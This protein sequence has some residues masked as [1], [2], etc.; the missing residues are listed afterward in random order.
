MDSFVQAIGEK[1]EFRSQDDIVEEILQLFGR[2]IEMLI[3]FKA[4]RG[5]QVERIIQGIRE[6]M[7]TNAI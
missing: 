3:L 2:G 4:S 1:A 5:M 6:R 7:A